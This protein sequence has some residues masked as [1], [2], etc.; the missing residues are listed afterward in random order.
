MNYVLKVSGDKVIFGET[1]AISHEMIVSC[2]EDE[3]RVLSLIGKMLRSNMYDLDIEVKD[4]TTY[5][6]I[7]C[8]EI[9]ALGE[10]M[11]YLYHAGQYNGE[12]IL[13]WS[14][15]ENHR[16]TVNEVYRII[17]QQIL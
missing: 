6:K 17:H 5:N 4:V 16:L 15:R 7:G 12:V 3:N 2:V 13:L 10:I 14:W 8:I 9:S 11:L 1:F